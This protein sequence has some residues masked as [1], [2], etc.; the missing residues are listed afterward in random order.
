MSDS[1]ELPVIDAILD[2]SSAAQQ[3]EVRNGTSNECSLVPF[4]IV[5]F[6]FS[7]SG[8]VALL[9]SYESDDL[10][11]RYMAVT[12]LVVCFIVFFVLC[13]IKELRKMCPPLAES[14]SRSKLQ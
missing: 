11:L 14:S 7:V 3:I 4:E 1:E 8:S 12:V 10:S 13:F 9:V 2:P 5:T 6:I